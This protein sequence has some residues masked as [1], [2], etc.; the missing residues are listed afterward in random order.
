MGLFRKKRTSSQVEIRRAADDDLDAIVVLLAELVT[1]TVPRKRRPKYLEA[2]RAD[3]KKRFRDPDTVW[4]VA[5]RAGTIVG[6]AR[7]DIRTGHPLLAYLED[8]QFGYLFGVFVA[9]DERGQG[10]GS[11][12]LGACESWLKGRGVKWVFLHSAP[13]AVGFYSAV[14]YDP[15]FEFARRL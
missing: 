13:E 3:Q 11:R 7:A 2:V 12:L 6:C 15:S 9:A 5:T 14:G 10:T 4:F 8:R 1:A